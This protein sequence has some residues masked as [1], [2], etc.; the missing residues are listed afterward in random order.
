MRFFRLPQRPEL[1]PASLCCKK[2][3]ERY[4]QVHLYINLIPFSSLQNL[5]D[6]ESINVMM[7]FQAE[8]RKRSRAP[9][10]NWQ[11]C[12]SPV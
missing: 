6:E 8:L 12:L 7:S 2:I 3:S 1:A 5:L 10:S 11:R 9:F 4:P